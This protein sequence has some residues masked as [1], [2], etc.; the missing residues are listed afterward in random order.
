MELRNCGHRRKSLARFNWGGEKI[1]FIAAMRLG[2]RPQSICSGLLSREKSTIIIVL[3]GS[4]SVM[5][6]TQTQSA[7]ETTSANS[8]KNGFAIR[9]PPDPSD[10]GS[11]AINKGPR[12]L[13]HRSSSLGV[14]EKGSTMHGETQRQLSEGTKLCL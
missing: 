13:R 2:S 9:L 6:I 1:C 5:T 10:T 11:F 3:L 7:K 4:I 8:V 12:S 14:G